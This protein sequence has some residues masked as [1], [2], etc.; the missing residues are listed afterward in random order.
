MAEELPAVPRR[1]AD[2]GWDGF[3]SDPRAPQNA[4]YR[5]RDT[6][7]HHAVEILSEGYTDGRL[8]HSE[9]EERLDKAMQVRTMAEFVPLVDDLLVPQRPAGARPLVPARGS[10]T[11]VRTVWI[12]WGMLALLFNL[13]WV[14]TVVGTGHWIYWWPFWP[15]LGTAIPAVITSLG[16]KGAHAHPRPPVPPVQIAPPFQQPPPPGSRR[17]RPPQR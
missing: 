10:S 5:A 3:A 15:M 11:G 8:T 4:A 9:Y 13:I 17:P 2:L 14:A 7:R 1:G 6:D 16:L 12:S